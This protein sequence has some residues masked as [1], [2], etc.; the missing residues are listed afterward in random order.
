MQQRLEVWLRHELVESTS[1]S[2]ASRG[3]GERRSHSRRMGK[4]SGR[5]EERLFARGVTDGRT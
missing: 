4:E 5:S 1:V 2:K 3:D